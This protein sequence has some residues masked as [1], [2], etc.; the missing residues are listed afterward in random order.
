MQT[1]IGIGVIYIIDVLMGFTPTKITYHSVLG[2][3][4]QNWMYVVS[5]ILHFVY[6]FV[7]ILTAFYLSKFEKENYKLFAAFLLYIVPIRIVFE[8]VYLSLGH[9]PLYFVSLQDKM[10]VEP[11]IL[12]GNFYVF[13]WTSFILTYSSL[14]LYVYWCCK[15]FFKYWTANFRKYFLS[16]GL[17]S[18]AI[19][20]M[21]WY[22]LLG[23][24]IYGGKPAYYFF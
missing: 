15:V 1:N 5:F 7:L 8:L 20:L 3:Y 11:I 19:G 16:I 23:P 6:Q 13:K 10:E 4:T 9:N 14:A 21:S 17:V 2:C 12:F 24:L 18:C 22:F